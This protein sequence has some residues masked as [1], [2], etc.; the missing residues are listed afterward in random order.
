VATEVVRKPVAMDLHGRQGA[1][2]RSAAKT[3]RTSAAGP[4]NG[5]HL[6]AVLVRPYGSDIAV[7]GIAVKDER[8][9]DAAQRPGRRAPRKPTDKIQLLIVDEHPLMRAGVRTLLEN[10][11]AVEVVAEANSIADALDKFRTSSPDVVLM[12]LDEA[13]TGAVDDMRRLRDEMSD[14]AALVVLSRHEDDEG[15]FRAVVG[16]ASGHVGENADP[17]EL[18]DTIMEAALGHDPISRTIAQRPAVGRRV[19]EAYAEM[20]AREPAATEQRLT[21]RE[22][23]ILTLAAQGMT[24]QQIGRSLGV[25]EHTIKSAI[26]HVLAR[27]GLRHRTEA[28]VHALR[29]GWINPLSAHEIT[30]AGDADGRFTG[31][32]LI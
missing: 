3:A 27:L 6:A 29:H 26:S 28:V 19:L 32:D 18:V 13:T 8:D 7:K 11:D 16:G 10:E 5:C 2:V 23:S 24:N 25:S 20:S 21:D 1:K 12:D 9:P 17:E 31:R 4:T 14:D 30:A 22:A 15:V